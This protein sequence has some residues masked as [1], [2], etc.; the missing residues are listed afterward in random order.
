MDTPSTF[1]ELVVFLIDF[2]QLLV[3]GVFALTFLVFMWKLIDAWIIHA[4]E[5]GSR[6][7]GRTL[8][9]T[10]AVVLTIMASIWGILAILQT[11]FYS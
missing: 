11:A 4:D 1:A 8:V 7:G 9:V 6:E 5:S 3:A 2:I 10:A